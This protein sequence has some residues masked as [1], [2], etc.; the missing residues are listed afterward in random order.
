MAKFDPKF[1]RKKVWMYKGKEI[2]S[3]TRSTFEGIIEQQLKELGVNYE[4]E[5]TVL[6]WVRKI[7]S[8]KCLSC[9]HS[10][11]GQQCDYTPD[12]R[13]NRGQRTFF[14]E[15]KGYLDGPDRTKLRAIKAQYPDLDIRI[16]FQRD[17]P[18]KGTKNKTRYSEWAR[19]Y[20]FVYS[21]GSVPSEWFK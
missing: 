19:K 13:I 1:H 20:G 11:V 10:E 18:I 4:Y 9:G 14:I 2:T 6:P 12:F 8:G 16:V 17:N 15:V 5:S 7:T 21:V 3:D